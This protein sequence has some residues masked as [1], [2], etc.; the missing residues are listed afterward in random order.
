VVGETSEQ[1]QKL[2][3]QRLLIAVVAPVGLLL[4]V[5]LILAFQ[6]VK[7]QDT[8]HWVDHTDEVIGRISEIQTQIVDQ[9]T[10][11]RGFLLTGDRAF[12]APYE[13]AQPL[14]MFA[15]VHGLV[16]DNPP[17][18]VRVDAARAR[19]E[20]WLK[21]NE[22]LLE[23]GAE[24]NRYRLQEELLER[25][26]RMDSIREALQNMLLVEQGLRVERASAYADSN[27]LTTFLG[28][29][30]FIALATGL[31]FISRRQLGEVSTTYRG[32]LEGERTARE[33]VETQDWIRT[34]H[35]KVAESVQGDPAPD[36]LGRRALSELCAH[37]GAVA[38][39]FFVAE[40]GGFRRRA[41]L[42]L[43][44]EANDWFADGEGLVGR[45][46]I[47][48]TLLRVTAL[49]AAFAKIESGTG[50]GVPTELVLLPA[51]L[52]GMTLA[53]LEFA[54]FAP[55]GERALEL[56]KRVSETIAVALR[57]VQQ[58]ERLA[59]LLEEAQRQAEELQTQQEELRVANEELEQQGDVLRGAHAQL[60]EGKEELE[61][62]NSSLSTQRDALEK[63]QRALSEKMHQLEKASRYKSEFLANMSHELRTPLN[64]SLI[65]AKLLADNK[66][67][68]LNAEQ[69]KFATTIYSA[70]NDLLAL[71]NDILDLSKIEAGKVDIRAEAISV[72][73]LVEPVART[74]D[75]VAKQKNVALALSLGQAQ[76]SL[77]TDAQRVQQV[78]KN[79]LSNAFKFT[80][81]GTVSLTVEA[82]D[83]GYSFAVRDTGIGIAKAHHASIFE[84]F[85]QADG[86]TNRRFGG[87]GLGLAIS[88][89]LAH[90]LGGDL[91]VESEL[92][93]GSCFTLSLPKVFTPGASKERSASPP[94]SMTAQGP[95]YATPAP[96]GPTVIE[97]PAFD[98]DRAQIDPLRRLLLIIED[99]VSFAEILAKLANE[100]SFQF[101]VAHSADEGVRLATTFLPA[102]IILDMNL[103][104][105]IGLTALDRLKQNGL[106]RHI[107]VHVMSVEDYSHMALSMGAAG[108]LLKPVKREELVS[109]FTGM[110]ERFSRMR[111]LLVVEDD[112]VQRD[113]VI[114]LLSNEDVEIVGVSTVADAQRQLAAGSFD[115]IVTDLSLP[116][117]TGYDLLERMAENE[118]YAFPPVIVYTGRSL[119]A[120]EEQKLR[121]FSSS[122]IVK[123][124]RSPERLLDEVTLFLHQVEAKLPADRQRMLR[125]ARDREAA[126]D[127]RKILVAEDD[128]RNIFALSSILEPKGA[129]LYIAR[130]GR[131]AIEHLERTPDID[132]VLMDIMMPE[133]DGLEATRQIRAG[134]GSF[135]KVPIIALTAKAMGDDRDL[136]IK[137]G[138]NDYIAKPLD[139]EILLSLVR[140]WLHKR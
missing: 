110:K 97:T 54:F 23:L 60:E 28:V 96:P 117:A 95:E 139:V 53:V 46:A 1:D 48:R 112:A 26:R 43:A 80:E 118:S 74:F 62:S 127:G 81:R 25:K 115:C 138:A 14:P 22:P 102:A 136:C 57:S 101:L 49:P 71:I 63:A 40:P 19:Y 100:L 91:T 83:A 107:P 137:A 104:D 21:M 45:A 2:L 30:L 86:T 56:L 11:I 76:A 69:V 77:E 113:A 105:R 7:L 41:N 35:M 47:A 34:Q 120:D 50:A 51:C 131:E 106:T 140:V 122:I 108:Y 114:Q 52:E 72:A 129:K 84:A 38:G 132:L 130:N 10:G 68:N 20:A 70:G 61:T 116:D 27:R 134:N 88:R 32:L 18:Q 39:A 29:P 4:L 87:T 79:L 42:G 124:A 15:A 67:G 126:F 109:V 37:T 73:R 119:T 135:S 93:E 85:Q 44:T 125:L 16:A 89:D 99:D 133:L 123:G 24:L 33:L 59:D 8:A 17:Q 3:A 55:V 64:S 78:L 9:E 128:V 82:N 6:V 12:L 103:P 111:R 65:L 121:R 66:D 31:A 36:E 75:P 5:G 58:K 92:G 98:D 90:M 94:A 13:R